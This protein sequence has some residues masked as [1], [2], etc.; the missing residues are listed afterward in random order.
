MA[1]WR[2]S[3]VLT[4]SMF[5]S[6]SVSWVC[7]SSDTLFS[8]VP[9][10]PRICD[11]MLLKAF[12][13]TPNSSLLEV[14]TSWNRLPPAMALAES[15]SFETGRM[16]ILLRSVTKKM[17]VRVIVARVAKM[18]KLAIFFVSALTW[19]IEN[20]RSTAATAFRSTWI[21]AI[22][23]RFSLPSMVTR[24]L[25]ST[26]GAIA[27]WADNAPNA[28]RSVPAIERYSRTGACWYTGPLRD[29]LVISGFE[30]MR[31]VIMLCIFE[32][33]CR[34]SIV[35]TF[36]SITRETHRARSF[37]VSAFPPDSIIV[38]MFTAA[39]DSPATWRG[40]VTSTADCPFRLIVRITILS[41]VMIFFI[42]GLIS[43]QMRFRSL[44]A[45]VR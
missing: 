36:A 18:A 30:S 1:S 26:I 19:S 4:S 13:S 24:V 41:A 29:N 22:T 35:L 34:A 39:R 17:V 9:I 28:L 10:N 23:R 38:T 37:A 3:L 45:K 40:A 21:G 31:L 42:S 27:S 33:Y 12:A 14:L 7:L 25:S 8:K 11:A 5:C 44:L 20:R 16:I 32:G 43:V 15:V 2:A 6:S